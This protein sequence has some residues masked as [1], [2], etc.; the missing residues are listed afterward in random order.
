[1]DSSWLEDIPKA[2]PPVSGFSVTGTIGKDGRKEAPAVSNTTGGSQEDDLRSSFSPHRTLTQTESRGTG[3]EAGLLESGSG[4]YSPH[5]SLTVPHNETLQRMIQQ[6]GATGGAE[7]EDELVVRKSKSKGKAKK[8]KKR[9]KPKMSDADDTGTSQSVAVTMPSIATTTQSVA[10]T[11][12]ATDM[13]IAADDQAE[14]DGDQM[15]GAD[16]S[17]QP[18]RAKE[19]EEEE[20][21]RGRVNSPEEQEMPWE[22]WTLGG[23]VVT[24]EGGA[25]P[26]LGEYTEECDV[27]FDRLHP[28]TLPQ[29]AASNKRLSLADE[30]E[31]AMERDPSPEA[32]RSRH[33]DIL[34]R[35]TEATPHLDPTPGGTDP[36]PTLDPTPSN[37][38]DRLSSEEAQQENPADATPPSDTPLQ[39]PPL[40]VT[41][42]HHLLSIC[43]TL[44]AVM[45]ESCI[46]GHIFVMPDN[47]APVSAK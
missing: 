4:S 46:N 14:A 12:A 34:E 10:M 33:D 32:G 7:G 31:L 9:K 15:E 22:H 30:L 11:T 37:T 42:N 35:S 5:S 26:A 44:C 25:E 20:E 18:S 38:V 43:N 3:E 21:E 19:G 23:G 29:P 36:P 47:T 16:S 28:V 41:T 6:G 17:P 13:A 39:T 2:A 27:G 8:K 40:Q 1:M 24:S 45:R